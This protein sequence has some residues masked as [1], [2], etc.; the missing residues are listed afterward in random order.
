MF[1]DFNK[2]DWVLKPILKYRNKDVLLENFTKVIL[3][4]AWKKHLKLQRK[5]NEE[6]ETISIED[7]IKKQET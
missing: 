3:E 4:P 6:L 7:M 2:Y 5:K 1:K